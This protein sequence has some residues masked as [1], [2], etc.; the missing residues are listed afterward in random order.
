LFE[1]MN[2]PVVLRGKGGGMALLDSDC[3]LLMA[4]RPRK[5]WA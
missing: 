5:T 3:R 2:V 1:P 4:Q